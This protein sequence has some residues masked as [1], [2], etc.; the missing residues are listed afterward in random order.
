M[1]NENEIMGYLE[2]FRRTG[3]SFTILSLFE[4]LFLI[5]ILGNFIFIILLN[6]KI[7]VLADTVECPENKLIIK[8]VKAYIGISIAVSLISAIFIL[9]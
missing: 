5:S 6:N 1:N 3:F 8:I 7:N 4:F 2:G 9:L